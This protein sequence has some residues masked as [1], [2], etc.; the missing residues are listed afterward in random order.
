MFLLRLSYLYASVQFVVV[1][2][3]KVDPTYIFCNYWL[4]N[5][6]SNT[7]FIYSHNLLMYHISQSYI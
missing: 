5:T 6:I 7:N 3:T 1:K 4:T 2:P